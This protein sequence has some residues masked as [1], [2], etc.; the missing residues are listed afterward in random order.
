MRSH[1]QKAWT[2]EDSFQNGNWLGILH[3]M[4]H[5]IEI[6]QNTCMVYSMAFIFKA[7]NLFPKGY[8]TLQHVLILTQNTI[9]IQ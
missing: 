9:I 3:G 6:F 4:S 5:E 1:I 2:C 8:R 7:V